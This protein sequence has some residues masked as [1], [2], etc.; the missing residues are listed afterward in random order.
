MFTTL[1]KQHL[2]VGEERPPWLMNI[3]AQALILGIHSKVSKPTYS[4]IENLA[5]T[6]FPSRHTKIYH[7]SPH[8]ETEP[9]TMACPYST[10]IR[11]QPSLEILGTKVQAVNYRPTGWHRWPCWR[12][13]HGFDPR[14][15]CVYFGQGD[16]SQALSL[17]RLFTPEPSPM[18]GANCESMI[19]AWTQVVFQPFWSRGVKYWKWAKKLR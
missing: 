16:K 14:W 2:C 5:S 9:S 1:L 15:W 7:G 6:H 19:P 17:S 13:T 10:A 4:C 3:P 11:S 12:A 18:N 8:S